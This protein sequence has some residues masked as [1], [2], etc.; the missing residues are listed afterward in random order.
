MG[1]ACKVIVGNI[2]NHNRFKLLKDIRRT[3]ICPDDIDCCHGRP[4]SYVHNE[5]LIKQSEAAAEPPSMGAEVFDDLYEETGAFSSSRRLSVQIMNS[6][7]VD[8]NTFP[9][10]GVT[11]YLC[12]MGMLVLLCYRLYRHF[13]RARKPRV[14]ELE[15]VVVESPVYRTSPSRARTEL[16]RY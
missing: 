11:F 4:C 8:A 15:E 2:G 6:N 14:T 9:A 7:A 5:K 12:L 1:W 10:T 13:S 16:F 3:T